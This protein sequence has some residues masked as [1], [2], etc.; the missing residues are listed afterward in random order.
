MSRP[1]TEDVTGSLA[2]RPKRGQEV[3]TYLLCTL[4]SFQRPSLP[5]LQRKASDSHRRPSD[6]RKSVVS[7]GSGGTLLVE[8][9]GR[10]VAASSEAKAMIAATG[11][12]SSS[13]AEAQETA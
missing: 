13:G 5:R 6:L 12:A 9:Q 10:F 2:P 1:R 4:L 3:S 11:G 7:V 8:F